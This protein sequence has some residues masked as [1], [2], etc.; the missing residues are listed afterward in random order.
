M[1]KPVIRIADVEL[2]PRPAAFAASMR[3]CSSFWRAAVKYEWET[4]CTRS[5]P[6]ISP[7]VRRG[8]KERAHQII[9]TG[10]VELKYLAVSTRLSPEIADY[11]D[12]GKFGVL[13]EF[14]NDGAGPPQTFRLVGRESES[15][16]Y[17]KGE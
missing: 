16:D 7:P 14:R 3:K 1:I 8:G 17:W 6:A 4:R 9:N 15:I 10:D 13:A 12:L 5:R 2:L 11:P